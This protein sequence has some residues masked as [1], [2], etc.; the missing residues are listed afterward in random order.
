MCNEKLKAGVI[1]TYDEF[2]KYCKQNRMNPEGMTV[3]ATDIRMSNGDKLIRDV[4]AVEGV[5]TTH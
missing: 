5:I 1:M 2:I 3:W 4:R